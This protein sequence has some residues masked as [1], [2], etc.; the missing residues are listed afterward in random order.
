M[1]ISSKNTEAFNPDDYIQYQIEYVW[2]NIALPDNPNSREIRRYFARNFQ[3]DKDSLDQDLYFDKTKAPEDI[4]NPD[5][6]ITYASLDPCTFYLEHTLDRHFQGDNSP[7]LIIRFP[8][9]HKEAIDNIIKEMIKPIPTKDPNRP[10]Q[11]YC[12]FENSMNITGVRPTPWAYNQTGYNPLETLREVYGCVIP[13]N[14]ID[15]KLIYPKLMIDKKLEAE[16]AEKIKN[17]LIN[18]QVQDL[19]TFK[20]KVEQYKKSKGIVTGKHKL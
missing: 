8:K 15:C 9:E 5:I 17:D 11:S 7:N 14:E 4:S 2:V 13:E 18:K 16:N 6:Y 3:M 10:I 20:T 19:E 1:T 12:T